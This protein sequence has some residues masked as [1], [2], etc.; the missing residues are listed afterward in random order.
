MANFLA[1]RL[2][3]MV[4]LLSFRPQR[5]S[6]AP[7]TH[8][9]TPQMCTSGR[10]TGG[11]RQAPPFPQRSSLGQFP[12][13]LWSH[14]LSRLSFLSRSF[15]HSCQEDWWQR[16]FRC[17]AGNKNLRK[18]EIVRMAVCASRGLCWANGYTWLI[19]ELRKM[20]TALVLSKGRFELQTAN[21]WQKKKRRD[22]GYFRKKLL[23]K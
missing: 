4:S 12:L 10:E 3:K 22:Q 9:N 21:I 11:K 19:W 17:R 8:I 18:P 5:V 23:Q 2:E 14:I 16:K 13:R 1:C 20:M 7:L 15:E 6:T